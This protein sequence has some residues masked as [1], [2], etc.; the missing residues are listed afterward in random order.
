MKNYHTEQRARLQT[1]FRE[2]AERQ[3]TVEEAAQ[4]LAG[5]IS[6]SAV[7]RNVNAMVAAGVLR[8][9]SAEGS[10]KALYQYFGGQDCAGHIHMKCTVCGCVYHMDHAAMEA[11]AASA[12]TVAGGFHIDSRKTIL[13]GECEKCFVKENV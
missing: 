13:Y 5:E 2:N 11:V 9:F 4:A 6:A 7:Y 10:R 8:R 12:E 1:F 3:F